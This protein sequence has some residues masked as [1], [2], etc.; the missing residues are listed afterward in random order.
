MAKFDAGLAVEALEYDFSAYGGRKGTIPEPST[1]KVNQFFD[2]MREFLKE[3]RALAGNQDEDDGPELEE[4]SEEEVAGALDDMDEKIASAAGYQAKT[5]EAV[6]VLCGAERLSNPKWEEDNDEPEYVVEGGAPSLDDLNT[7]PYRVLAAFNK[8]LI[9][10]ITP[11]SDRDEDRGPSPKQPQDR[12][13]PAGRS[14]A[15]KR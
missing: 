8:W 10:E 14:R 5:V 13:P 7:L 6:A 12:R 15:A 11:K 4:L 3:A 2:D 1:V 9:Q